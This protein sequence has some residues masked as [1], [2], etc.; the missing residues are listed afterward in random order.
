MRPWLLPASRPEPTGPVEPSGQLDYPVGRAVVEPFDKAHGHD[1]SLFVPEEYGD[2]LATSADIYAAAQLRAR[3]VSTVRIRAFKGYDENKTAVPTSPAARLL[4]YVN[5]HWTEA[6]LAR[7]DELSMCLWGGSVWA[8][9]KDAFG[10]P[11]EIWW[12]KPSRVKPVPDEKDYI[13]KYRYESNVNG[14]VLE[15]NADEIVWF[16][17]PNPLDEFAAMSPVAAARLAADTG[18]AMM[19][20]NRQLHVNGAQAAGIVT[21]TGDRVRYTKDQADQLAEDIQ[22]RLT[23][24]KNAHRWVVLRYEAQFHPL[25]ITPKDAEYLGGMA[26]TL[27]QVCNAYG[28]PAPLLN[29]LE[30]ATL[31]N[32]REFQKA[33][34]EHALVPDLGLRAQ[35]IEEQ[36]LPMFR[37]DTKNGADHVEHDFS[38]VAALQESQSA[39]WDRERQAIEIGGMTINEWRNGR[40][41]PSVPW[42]DVFW[43]PV[44]KAPVQ[45]ATAPAGAESDQGST[46]TEN[47]RALAE[48]V[49][50]L[51]LGVRGNM[52]LSDKEGRQLLIA[53]GLDIPPDMPAEGSAA[54]PAP[55]VDAPPAGDGAPADGEDG[56]AAVA[57]VT[58]QWARVLAALDTKELATV[59]GRNGHGGH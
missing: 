1:G 25:H 26:L 55:A 22:T 17:Y 5:P 12:L 4:R 42:G 23:G 29:D 15:F 20:S 36:F 30:H 41:L 3:L 54:D 43:A 13:K 35:E 56:G 24:T 38:K 57:G 48:I 21:P 47:A 19:R 50:K 7:M 6:R 51:Y 11:K 52:L 53:A 8:I 33:L 9:E 49:Q 18:S 16:R 44:N 31:A 10:Q 58:A 46:T 45:N 59:G 27:R 34:W 28:I 32:L 37:R 2:Y 14:Q 40:G 39:T